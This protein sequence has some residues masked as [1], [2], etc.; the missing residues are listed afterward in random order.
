MWIGGSLAAALFLELTPLPEGWNVWRPP[1]VLLTL[2]YWTMA[3]PHR[4]GVAVA[5]TSGLLVDAATGAL[6]GQHALGYAVTA[7]LMLRLHAQLRS[8]PLLQQALTMALLLLPYMSI[9]L[10]VRGV[11][12]H[13]P[14]SWSYWLPLVSTAPA[15]ILLT[16]V[17]GRV[18][19]LRPSGMRAEHPDV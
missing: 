1:W 3:L 10:W 2:L 15:W 9:M 4:V 19:R 6:L 13:P 17:L 14:G 5:W 7:Y 18:A 12:G 11:A 8:F 16:V